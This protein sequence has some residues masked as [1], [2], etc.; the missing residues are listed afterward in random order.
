MALLSGAG[1][2][3]PVLVR[4]LW[5]ASLFQGFGA[6]LFPVW[7]APAAARSMA[8][9]SCPAL[10]CGALVLALLAGMAWLVLETEALAGSATP[11][12][13]HV[14][15]TDTL[16]GHVLA[17]QAALVVIALALALSGRAG[18]AALASG[19]A[20]VAQAWHLHAAAMF[21][22]PSALLAC[23]SL[24]VLAG[25]AWLG[26]LLPLG[27]LIRA[28]PAGA[29]FAAARRYS[30]FGMV[31][32]TLL[33]ATALW[34]GIVLIGG[35]HAL[36][37]SA[38]G[39]VALVKLFLFAVLI[40]FAWRHHARLT[41]ALA[42]TRGIDVRRLLWRSITWEAMIGL[43]VVLAAAILAALPPGMDMGR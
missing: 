21:T 18:P 36:G 15:L 29:G 4:A 32:V 42:G 23:E 22:G 10:G 43:L 30:P 27:L 25:A 7:L 33:A 9:R 3:L 19:L 26:S 14:V 12:N 31:C 38:Y 6:L 16:Y 24:H 28:A 20:V 1:G 40:G 17:T 2:L 37:F 41:P 8:R 5:L 13:M 34:Q 35:L 39:R 11:G